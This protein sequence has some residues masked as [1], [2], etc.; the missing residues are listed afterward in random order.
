MQCHQSIVSVLGILTVFLTLT[1]WVSVQKQECA[2]I[3]KKSETKW[4]DGV[5][6]KK[7]TRLLKM[8]KVDKTEKLS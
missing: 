7:S 5:M 3:E 6:K 1:R 4:T 2:L 8:R